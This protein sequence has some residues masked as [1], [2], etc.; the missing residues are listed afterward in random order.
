MRGNLKLVVTGDT[1]PELYDVVAD[2]GE[3]RSLHAEHPK[4][5]KELQDELKRWI[6]TESEA[7]KQR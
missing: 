2:P 6:A 1:A 5:V 4:L 7:S 3:M